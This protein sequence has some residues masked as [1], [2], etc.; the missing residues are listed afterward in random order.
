VAA[1]ATDIRMRAEIRAGELLAEMK[2]NKGTRAQLRGDV[3][4][5][6]RAQKPPIDNT[7]KLSDLGVTKMQSHRWQKLA[8]LPKPTKPSR[9]PRLPSPR[10][11]ASNAI[12]AGAKNPGPPGRGQGSETLEQPGMTPL[13]T[14]TTRSDAEAFLS[15]PRDRGV[16]CYCFVVPGGLEAASMWPRITV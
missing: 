9:K 8:A 5:G 7:P 3:P 10:Q 12:E 16:I 1:A 6:G 4:I 15:L 14:P 2:K 13:A 11:S